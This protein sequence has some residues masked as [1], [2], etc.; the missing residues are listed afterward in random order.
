MFK[1]CKLRAS[2]ER[3]YRLRN[4]EEVLFSE[5]VSSVG[6][7]GWPTG[8]Q[9]VIKSDSI[10]ERLK[11]WDGF[12]GVAKE[13]AKN[14]VFDAFGKNLKL[15]SLILPPS[16]TREEREEMKEIIGKWNNNHSNKCEY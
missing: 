10:L 9:H 15:T 3:L 5:L 13:E 6:P 4:E 7:G 1:G 12:I 14:R 11:I 16:W 8:I 2:Q